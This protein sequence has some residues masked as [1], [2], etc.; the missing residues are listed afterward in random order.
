MIA[1]SIGIVVVNY[2]PCM[3][4]LVASYIET[5]CSQHCAMCPQQGNIFCSDS[6]GQFSTMH[7]WLWGIAL[8]YWRNHTQLSTMSASLVGIF[9]R[10]IVINFLYSIFYFYSCSQFF[11]MHL[12]LVVSSFGKAIVNFVSCMWD[13]GS[14]FCSGNGG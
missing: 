12:E 14:I 7:L 5:I 1:S 9:F 2:L 8:L 10:K 11:A 4:D 6:L 13:L 3:C